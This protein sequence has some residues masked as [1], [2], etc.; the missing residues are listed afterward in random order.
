MDNHT[1]HNPNPWEA[2]AQQQDFKVM[3]VY[4]CKILSQTRK[5][6]A[7]LKSTGIIQIKV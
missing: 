6:I 3:L 4:R 5:H 7:D 1:P 2:E